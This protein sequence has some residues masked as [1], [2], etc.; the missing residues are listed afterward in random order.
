MAHVV[1]IRLEASVYEETR[2]IAR[3][4]GVSM[5]ALI[6]RA[7]RKEIKLEQEREMYEAATLLGQDADSEVD[8]AFAVQAEVVM[9]D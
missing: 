7:L 8:Y 1:S 3:R 9:G 5:N 2:L 4:R 6:E